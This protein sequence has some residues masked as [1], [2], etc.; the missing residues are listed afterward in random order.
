L[1]SRNL[2]LTDSDARERL[3][4]WRGDD[5]FMIGWC[6]ESAFDQPADQDGEPVLPVTA[7]AG[8]AAIIS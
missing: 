7:A 1:L 5:P 4:P 2:A 8:V 6:D 3:A